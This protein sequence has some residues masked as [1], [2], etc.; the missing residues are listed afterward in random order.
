M[1]TRDTRTGAFEPLDAELLVLDRDL[2]QLFAEVEQILCEALARMPAAPR[3]LVPVPG[4]RAP[5]RPLLSE[6]FQRLRGRRPRTG[7]ATQRGPPPRRGTSRN[8]TAQPEESEV[9]PVTDSGN[10]RR[11][12][13][14]VPT[15]TRRI[16]ER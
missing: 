10:D 7:R 16:R 6:Y 13:D 1:T 5:A 12:G 8:R 14:E 3:P 15:P 11:G 9:M 4:L 2:E